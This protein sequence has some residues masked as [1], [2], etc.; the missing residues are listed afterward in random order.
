MTHKKMVIHIFVLNMVALRSFV[1][2]LSAYYKVFNCKFTLCV[3]FYNY[4]KKYYYSVLY[5]Q[6]STVDTNQDLFPERNKKLL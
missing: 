6:N 3:G 1:Y 4:E 2:F 5:L